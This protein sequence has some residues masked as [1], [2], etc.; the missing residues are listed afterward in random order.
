MTEFWAY[1]TNQLLAGIQ[2]TMLLFVGCA[3]VGNLLAIPI[4][5]A[6]LVRA[7]ARCADSSGRGGL[8]GQRQRQRQ[9]LM[10]AITPAE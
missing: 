8:R 6:R 9:V 3:A 5:V 1:L 10:R 4:A 7:W 2:V